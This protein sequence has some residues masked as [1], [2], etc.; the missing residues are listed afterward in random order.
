MSKQKIDKK[1]PSRVMP[2]V[3]EYIRLYKEQNYPIR[4]IAKH[5]QV[6]ISTVYNAMVAAGFSEFRPKHSRLSH[7]RMSKEE[8]A[9]ATLDTK[10]N[11]YRRDRKQLFE[12][13]FLL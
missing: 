11:I 5:F 7:S 2:D 12:R 9:I 1:K 13:K 6:A 3:S 8:Q 4:D 10:F